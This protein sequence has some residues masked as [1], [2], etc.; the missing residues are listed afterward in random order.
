MLQKCRLC[1]LDKDLENSHAIPNSYFKR[2]FRKNNG[3][4]KLLTPGVVG[5]K[6]TSESFATSQLC[7]ACE[8]HLNETYEKYSID[9]LRDKHGNTE[10]TSHG[11]TFSDIDV[12]TL[13][14]FFIS[15]FWRA[16][17]SDHQA[18][19]QAV[20]PEEFFHNDTSE[21]IREAIKN[22]NTIPSNL[23]SIKLSRLTDS[24]YGFSN[25]NLK[26]F[27]ALFFHRPY[28]DS[29]K[30]SVNFVIEGFLVTIIM[31]GLTITQKRSD[32]ILERKSRFFVAPFLEISRDSYLDAILPVTPRGAGAKKS[33][34]SLKQDK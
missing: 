12:N 18:Y 25:E 3:K 33:Y 6:N 32:N 31:P 8:K 14:M 10:T 1:Q 4:G 2:I 34:K 30:V 11:V 22:N 29:N 7:S 9:A 23:I 27:I 15:I 5:G 21:I 26:D 13:R 17:I 24:L 16:A 28:G 20:M 19:D